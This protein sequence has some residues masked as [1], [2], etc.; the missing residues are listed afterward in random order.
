[1]EMVEK[2][3]EEIKDFEDTVEKLNEERTDW[4]NEKIIFDDKKKDFVNKMDQKES[5]ILEFQRK[6]LKSQEETGIPRSQYTSALNEYK[7]LQERCSSY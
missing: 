6:L 2:L 1:M 3:R 4:Q 7:A 5:E